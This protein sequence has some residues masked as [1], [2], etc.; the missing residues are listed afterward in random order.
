MPLGGLPVP[1]YGTMAVAFQIPGTTPSEKI[2]YRSALVIGPNA[3]RKVRGMS[4]GPVEPSFRMACIA[5]SG[6]RMVKGE[7]RDSAAAVT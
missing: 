6:S 3:F 4:V 2:D 1:F 5:V 7:Q